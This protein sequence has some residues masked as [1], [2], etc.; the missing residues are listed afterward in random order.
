M[1]VSVSHR[2][3]EADE[4]HV[5]VPAPH[6]LTKLTRTFTTISFILPKDIT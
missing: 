5:S 6:R 4:F 3:T 2:V 1:V